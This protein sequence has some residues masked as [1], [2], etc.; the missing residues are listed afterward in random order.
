M[1]AGQQV[2][3]QPAQGQKIEA[4]Q[5]LVRK[6]IYSPMCLNVSEENSHSCQKYLGYTEKDILKT[7]Q[8]LAT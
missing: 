1:T 2:W 5:E 7:R 3:E 4:P 6:L 8:K